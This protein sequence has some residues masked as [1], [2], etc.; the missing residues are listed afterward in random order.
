[1]NDDDTIAAMDNASAAQS[2]RRVAVIGGGAAGLVAGRLFR[3][4]GI[5]V[6][7]LEKS[8]NI[9]GVWKYRTNDVIYRSLVT[10]LPK[11]IM[12]YFDEPFDSSLPV[13]LYSPSHVCICPSDLILSSLPLSLITPIQSFLRH[14]QVQSYLETYATKH[15]LDPLITLN[16]EVKSVRPIRPHTGP[17]SSSSSL[18]PSGDYTVF[19]SAVPE[20]PVWEVTYSKVRLFR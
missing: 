10:N 9:G 8:D 14:D 11:E 17:S 18:I 20:E 6:K 2:R 16:A 15:Q 1:M 4:A 3:D 5:Q 7:I 13:S 12:A 19:N